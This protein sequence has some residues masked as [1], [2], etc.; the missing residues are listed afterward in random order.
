M[1]V[2]R[3]LDGTLDNLQ[4]IKVFVNSAQLYIICERSGGVDLVELGLTTGRQAGS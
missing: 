1:T 3:K 2:K 4:R